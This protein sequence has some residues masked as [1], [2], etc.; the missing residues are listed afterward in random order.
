M[1]TSLRTQNVQDSWRTL[2]CIPQP[3]VYG[4]RPPFADK[5]TAAKFH[6]SPQSH[7]V[8]KLGCK[9]FVSGPIA[10]RSHFIS[11]LIYPNVHWTRKLHGVRT[12]PC[13]APAFTA[14]SPF[15]PFHEAQPKFNHWAEFK[16]KHTKKNKWVVSNILTC[17]AKHHLWKIPAHSPPWP[18]WEQLA[19]AG[20]SPWWRW[21]APF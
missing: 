14:I 6:G 7:W 3:S 16:K 12:K 8:A 1:F 19:G 18:S 21:L 15:K 11:S 20:K 13:K 9:D 2:H 17:L 4:H 10:W 5:E